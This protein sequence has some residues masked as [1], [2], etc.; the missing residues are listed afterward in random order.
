MPSFEEIKD[1]LGFSDYYEEEK[2]YS[3]SS[4]QPSSSKGE[5]K[6]FPQ[7]YGSFCAVL[8]FFCCSNIGYSSGDSSTYNPRLTS[9]DD[10]EKMRDAVVEVLTPSGY[11]NFSSDDSSNRTSGIWSRTLRLKIT[12]R[13]SLE[14]L[15]VRVPVSFMPC[16]F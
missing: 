3:I 11:K 12:G 10:A 9:G 1:I 6:I 14:K 13:D 5:Y 7:L 4:A 16:T 8:S 2:R 15:D